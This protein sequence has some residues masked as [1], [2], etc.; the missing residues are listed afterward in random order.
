VIGPGILRAGI[1]RADSAP[2]GPLELVKHLTTPP[3]VYPRPND[4]DF[5]RE[6]K[7]STD[8]LHTQVLQWVCQNI[9]HEKVS[10]AELAGEIR[11]LYDGRF[12]LPE[13]LRRLAQLPWPGAFYTWF[14]GLLHDCVLR[15]SSRLNQAVTVLNPAVADQSVAMQMD[16]RP[17]VLLRGS[18]N[19]PKSL[20]ITE[21]DHEKLANSIG[22][23]PPELS[24]ITRKNFPCSVLF[25][26]VSPRE[27]LVHQLCQALLDSNTKGRRVQGPTFFLCSSEE[28]PDQ[29]Y[30]SQYDTVWI[31]DDL[32]PF[33]ADLLRAVQ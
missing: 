14:D 17:L 6:D 5:C 19:Q 31:V 23:M 8:W 16:R 2:P 21:D 24:D 22:R 28:V 15:G 12:V 10:W 3:R 20:V 30:W 26:G 1:S 33:L 13:Q 29:A 27:P 11:A 7:P 18:V 9:V 32:D 25:I 4:L